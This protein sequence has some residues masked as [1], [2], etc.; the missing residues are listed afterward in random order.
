MENGDTNFLVG[1]HSYDS[2]DLSNKNVERGTS[3]AAP[4]I[5]GYVALLRHKF[6]GLNAVNTASIL[7]D[8]AGYEDLYCNP[9]CDKSIYGQGKANLG[10]AMSPIGNLR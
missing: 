6:S 5:S 2:A 10:K 4:R 7:L 1:N 9:N 3:Y 8:T